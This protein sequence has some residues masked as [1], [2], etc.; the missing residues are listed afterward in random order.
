MIASR[1]RLAHR[2]AGDDLFIKLSK[3]GKAFKQS[4]ESLEDEEAKLAKEKEE[5]WAAL[6]ALILHPPL[7]RRRR[8]VI[9]CGR[10]RNGGCS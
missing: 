10:S 3:L 6:A 7:L 9:L 1:L 5:A 4:L 8:P 2:Q